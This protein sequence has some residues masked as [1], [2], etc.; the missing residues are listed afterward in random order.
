M[1]RSYSCWSKRKT[2][3][4]FTQDRR[5][6]LSRKD[7]F[8]DKFNPK[9]I[10]IVKAEVKHAAEENGSD[11]SSAHLSSSKG[12]RASRSQVTEEQDRRPTMKLKQR[13]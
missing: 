2:A 8:T 12:K 13:R 7:G 1:F 5:H 11:G 6:G 9:I 10:L 4:C 3:C